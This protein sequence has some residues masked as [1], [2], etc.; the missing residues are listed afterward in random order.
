M[1]NINDYLKKFSKRMGEVSSVKEYVI[2]VIQKT[3]K[4]SLKKDDIEIKE[5]TLFLK[6]KPIVRSEVFLKKEAILKL[7]EERGIHCIK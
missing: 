3:T 5:G 2:E 7:L 4:A 6:V 1:F